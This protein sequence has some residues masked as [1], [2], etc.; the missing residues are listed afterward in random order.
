M[1]REKMLERGPS[2]LGNDELLAILLRTG[3]RGES[4]LKLARRLLDLGDGRLDNLFNMSLSRLQREPGIG[5]GK[6]TG[7]LA[8][9][10]LGRRFFREESG[11]ERKSVN[12]P[13]MVYDIMVPELKGLPHEECWVVFLNSHNYLLGK[14][15][16]SK[17]GGC[18]TIIDV[19]L[20]VKAALDRSASA[21]V[22][23]HNHPSGD[24]E[25]SMADMKE[26]E[27]LHDA[28]KTLNM[29]LMDH[30]IFCDGCFY[31]FS[32]ERRFER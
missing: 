29:A 7:V 2:S 31:S 21:L 16:L 6:A 19:A 28:C 8:A 23:V 3:S 14:M 18:S 12:S 1:P 4:V 32:E 24:P 10:E 13:R 25:P 15:Q 9:L 20:V 5:P 22:L 27:S 30:I 17:G 11:G 26:T